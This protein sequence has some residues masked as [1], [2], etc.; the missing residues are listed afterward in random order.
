MGGSMGRIHVFIQRLVQ[1]L[2]LREISTRPRKKIKH[3]LIINNRQRT[4]S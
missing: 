3:I 1:M 4:M 2:T